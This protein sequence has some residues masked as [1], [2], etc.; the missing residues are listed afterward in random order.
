MSVKTENAIRYGVAGR[1]P[2]IACVALTGTG[3]NL[4]TPQR[5][6]HDLNQPL[7]DP[8]LLGVTVYHDRILD[9]V[10]CYE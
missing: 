3:T 10:E 6:I 7:R 5:L 9:G 4:N 8:T 1:G 2:R